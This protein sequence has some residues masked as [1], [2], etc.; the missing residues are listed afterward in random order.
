MLAP[1][2]SAALSYCA[3]SLG[4]V[5]PILYATDWTTPVF[6][7]GYLSTGSIAGSLLQLVCLAGSV[8]LYI[9][10]VLSNRHY[11]ERRRKERLG[12]LQTAATQAADDENVN[13]LSRNDEVGETARD[14]SVLL[15]GYFEAGKL[16]FFLAYQP[17]TDKNGRVMGAEALVRWI[18]PE[19][20]YISPIVLVELCDESGLTS[21]LGR[22]ITRE[23]I[24]EYARWEQQGMGGLH[25]SV[26]LNA[27]HLKEDDGFASF[28]GETLAANGVQASR[29]E[30]EITEHIAMHA[31]DATREKVDALRELGL[32]L[33]IDDMGIG[34]SSLTYISDFGVTLVKLDISL[35]SHID[36]DV[37]QQEIVRSLIQLARQLDLTVVVEGVEAI[38]QVD[39]LVALGVEYFQGYYFSK[40]L[41]STDFTAYIQAHG[42]A[43]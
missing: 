1:L 32:S 25:L 18:H 7:S 21:D 16:P 30:L 42:L 35:V 15:H 8:F 33:S 6:L 41:E 3:F 5:P 10:F 19:L 4:L 29:L 24:E 2:L 38:E 40:P 11:D 14:V 31:N 27:R 17:K 13:V 37:T 22:W 36:T 9:P 43:H 20:G 39:A 34:Y 26:N 12:C 28:V 23:A